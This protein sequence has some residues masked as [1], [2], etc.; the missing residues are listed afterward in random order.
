MPIREVIRPPGFATPHPSFSPAV[1]YGRWVFVSGIMATDFADGI[2]PEARGNPA[3]PLAGEHAMVRESRHLFKLMHQVLE[4]SGA[5][6]EDAVRIDQFPTSRAMVDPYH[7]ERREIIKPPR[8]AST[9]VVITGLMAPDC[10]TEVELIAIRPEPGFVKEGVN[11]DKIPQPQGGYAPAIR[12]GDFVFVS[13]QVPTDF[14]T[15]L[16][17]ETIVHPNF[18]EGNAI[19]RQAR[20]TLQNLALTLEAAGSSMANVVKANVYLTDLEDIPRLDRVWREFFPIDP[21]ART[22]MPV[23][24][25]VVPDSRIEI[26]FVAVRDQGATRKEV[27][28]SGNAPAPIFHESQAIRAGEFV[29]LSNLLAADAGGLVPSARINPKFPYTVNSPAAQMEAIMKHAE[30]ICV[31]AGTG[32]RHGLRLLTQHTDMRDYASAVPLRRPYFPDGQPATTTIQV[33]GPLQIPGCT[34]SVDLWVG[35]P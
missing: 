20:F 10:N 4:A 11:T 24:S 9:S 12:A 33:P 18:W 2:A 28:R 16:A 29:F 5:R 30:A 3:V 7:I 31:A 6:I 8:P 19:D 15:G 21:P 27:I 32:L 17:P 14:R 13:G 23:T 25:I 1:R 26:T 22:I 34:I 35:V